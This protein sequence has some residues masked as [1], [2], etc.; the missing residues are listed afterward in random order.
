MGFEMTVDRIEKTHKG[1]VL[2]GE[3]G[4]DVVSIKVSRL[5]GAKEGDIILVNKARI[6]VLEDKTRQRREQ[7]IKLQQEL[8]D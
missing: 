2:T 6:T 3:R 7:I 4:E 8:S 1:Y 5:C